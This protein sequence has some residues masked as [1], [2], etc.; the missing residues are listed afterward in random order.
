MII[1]MPK[2]TVILDTDQYMKLIKVKSQIQKEQPT[3]NITLT[4]A[5]KHVLKK[6]FE[7]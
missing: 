6:G 3:K 5:V 7:N 1:I 2:V 4:D